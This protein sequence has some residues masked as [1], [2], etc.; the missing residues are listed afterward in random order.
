[1]SLIIKTSDPAVKTLCKVADKED[2]ATVFDRYQMQLPQC[3]FGSLG[4]CCRICYKGPCRVDPFGE[5]PQLGICGADRHTIVAR[6]V[7][8]M[9]AAGAAAHSEHGRHIALAMQK[10]G[11]GLLP[12]YRIRDEDKLYR[13][14]E[15]LD[16]DTLG[17]ETL[18]VAYDVA[19]KTLEDFQN[20][21]HHKGCHWIS[22]TLPDKRVDLLSR[23]GALPHN[24]DATVSQ[25][26]ARTHI[27]CDAEPNN[28]FLGGIRG[29]LAD[30]NGMS[31]ATELSDVMFGTPSPVVTE[32]NIGVID[33]D[34]VNIAVNGHNPLLS[35]VICD[36]ARDMNDIAKGAGAEK[37][38]NIVGICCTGNEVMMRHG[39]PL[40]TNYLSQEMAILTGALDAMVVDVQC[41]MPSLPQIGNCFHTEVITTMDENKMQG[42]RHISFHEE[43]AVE[44][45]REVIQC[46]INAYTR[47]D[48]NKINIPNIK[49]TAVVG[50]SSEA[51]IT[52]LSKLDAVD[53][54][55]PLV[56]NIVNGNIQ[57]VALFAGCNST[58]TVQD[59]SYQI[60]ARTLAANNV[61]LL[62]T[63]CGAGAF[64]KHGLM[65]QQATEQ[66]AG[67][68]L[69]AV[70]TQ[71]GEAAGLNGPL[72]LVLHMGSCVDNS[73]AVTLATA[74]AN[75][76]GVDLCDLPVVASAPE[77]MS[78]KA[79]AIAS[80]GVAIGLPTHLGTIPQVTGSDVV[81]ELMQEGAKDLFG[82][83]F[84]VETDPKIA[85][86]KLVEV[87]KGKRQGLGI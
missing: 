51:V 67:D 71:I 64:A 8:R 46:A 29:A 58:Q 41:I 22:A 1:M 87:I 36:I 77:A 5:G 13:I 4:L 60:I 49:Q 18:E 63:G 12:A 23:L 85:G 43:N 75:R 38:I 52:A 55:K 62:A 42:A 59:E 15:L 47:R 44:T 61:L 69:K 66:Y 86:N 20:Q 76:L 31:L 17:K 16:I 11:Q 10:V 6:N 50:F 65:N 40:A 3:G 78:E 39:V 30:F 53:P 72:P 2:I 74:L 7:T 27:G 57:G 14:A 25:I 37:G 68:S 26:M 19:T 21:D 84:I 35:E 48:P 80:W 73:R 54:L 56:D 34:A 81:T 70:L 28:V 33:Q 79:I 32:A 9:M 24:I 82:G 83:Y 45:A